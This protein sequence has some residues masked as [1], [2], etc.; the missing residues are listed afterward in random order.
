MYPPKWLLRAIVATGVVVAVA[1]APRAGAQP[2]PFRA[3]PGFGPVNF[4]GPLFPGQPRA[5]VFVNPQF[6][7][8]PG[9]PFNPDPFNINPQLNPVQFV[10]VNP[11]QNNPFFANPFMVNP[12]QNNPFNP[13]ANNPL[14]NPFNNPFNN[15]LNNPL[16][17]NPNAPN[18]LANPFANPFAP[19]V[20]TQPAIAIQQPGFLR[21]AGPDFQVNPF[22]GT[23]VKP[24]TGVA[25][26][27]DGNIFFRL[28]R[29]GTPTVFNPN[30]PRTNIYV[31]PVHGTF[32]NPTTG[33]IVRPGGTNVF[34]PW[35]P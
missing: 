17:L 11:F 7:N 23:A 4:P 8:V 19:A 16:G 34:L 32:L 27:A 31:D 2:N 18:L 6:P 26:T 9:I 20:F 10:P 13:F 12:F 25:Q 29:D 3:P 1:T 35:M 30:A 5:P 22:S 15:P 33:V 21:W 28:G 14:N 24:F